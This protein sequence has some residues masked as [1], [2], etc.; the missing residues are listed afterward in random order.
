METILFRALEP[1]LFTLPAFLPPALTLIRTLHELNG[2]DGRAREG[3]FFSPS[4][5]FDDILR[6]GLGLRMTA[7]RAGAGRDR[8]GRD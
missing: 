8:G 4:S 3:L 1:F 2:V 6:G 5:S 7:M